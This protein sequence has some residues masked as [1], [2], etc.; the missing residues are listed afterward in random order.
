MRRNSNLAL[1][2]S[3]LRWNLR[4]DF[5][6]LTLVRSLRVVRV[7]RLAT[8]IPGFDQI[9]AACTYPA[10]VLFSVFLLLAIG[11]Y[12]FANIG[13]ALFSDVVI[14]VVQRTTCLVIVCN[15]YAALMRRGVCLVPLRSLQCL[16][17]MQTPHVLTTDVGEVTRVIDV[18]SGQQGEK[19]ESVP[20][21]KPPT[22]AST[23]G[24]HTGR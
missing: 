19:N 1:L 24:A 9:L 8:H 13:V 18:V 5:V 14:E 2:T 3:R 10:R 7:I 6:I 16:Y 12:V 23:Q 20:A 15:A 4:H 21:P 22:N 11:V 17:R